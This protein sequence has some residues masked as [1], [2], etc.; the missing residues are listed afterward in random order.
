MLYLGAPLIGIERKTLKVHQWSW[1]I[2]K[3][4]NVYAN[5]T[6]AVPLMVPSQQQ[7]KVLFGTFISESV[8][9]KYLNVHDV[10]AVLLYFSKAYCSCSYVSYRSI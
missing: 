7:G 6:K 1:I 9:I 10:V 4:I 3:G 2:F 8:C 5:G